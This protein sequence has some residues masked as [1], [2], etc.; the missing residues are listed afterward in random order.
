[1]ALLIDTNA[2]DW[3][4]DEDL[5]QL[6]RPL[7]PGVAVHCA[8]DE[9][10]PSTVIMLAVAF[11]APGRAA[12]L[13]NLQLVQKLGAGVETIVRDRD[14]PAHVR[15]TRLKPETP[16]REIAEYCLA[17]VLAAQRNL[18]LHEENARKRIWEPVAPLEG[19]RTTV[20]VLGLGHIGGRTARTFASLGFRVIGW[21]RSAKTMEGV[22]CRH[23]ADALRDVL[24]ACDYVACVLPSTALTRDL[25]D[26]DMF[27]AMKPGAT[28][29]N[30]GRGDL[31]VDDALLESLDASHLGGAVLDVFRSEPL[32]PEHRFWTHPKITI[33][34]HVSGWHLTGGLQDVAE[35]YKRLAAGEGLL[36]EVD[37]AAEY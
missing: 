37:R 29:V 11:L 21:S 12:T 16:A 28:I 17:Y 15:V 2:P 14:L 8:G 4:R 10:D 6:F 1:M 3:M 19:S 9:F 7:L 18:H 23:G 24:A 31:I 34:P 25:F 36:H 13:P 32:P 30:V 26:A 27:A 22:E 35:N 33:T 5:T 20:G